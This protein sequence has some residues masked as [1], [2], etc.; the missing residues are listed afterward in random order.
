MDGWTAREKTC[1][2][3]TV[4]CIASHG[5]MAEFFGNF[6]IHRDFEILGNTKGLEKVKNVKLC[7]V[8]IILH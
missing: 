3:N 6:S 2:S 4:L 1:R 8:K 7:T 5:K